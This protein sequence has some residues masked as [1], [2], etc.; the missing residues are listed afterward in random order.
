MT[1]G[2]CLLLLVRYFRCKH[3]SMKYVCWSFLVIYKWDVFKFL[4][5]QCSSEMCSCCPFDLSTSEMFSCFFLVYLHLRCVH[6]SR[7]SI[8]KRHMFKFLIDL[9]RSEMC[10]CIQLTYVE[11]RYVNVSS[12]SIYKRELC[13][14]FPSIYTS[15]WNEN[16]SY[17]FQQQTPE[18]WCQ[19]CPTV[20]LI[21]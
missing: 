20:G 1:G 13:L 19:T 16:L 7:W 9:S 12:R 3:V 8:H 10:S 11:V 15:H 6:V 17:Y 14:C 18:M 21:L 2:G 5:D 4:F